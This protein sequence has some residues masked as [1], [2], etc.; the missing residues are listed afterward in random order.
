MT[1]PGSAWPQ[2]SAWH[3]T[4][5]VLGIL[6]VGIVVVVTVGRQRPRRD[7][8]F[9]LAA[10]VVTCLL[11][12]SDVQMTSMVSYRSH[13]IEHLV[14]ILVIAPL[15]A[16]GLSY[17][18]SRSASTCGLI[19]F[20]VLIPLYHLTRLGA[21]VMQ[22]GGGHFVELASFAAVGVWFWLPIYG[23]NR[24]MSDVQ[25]LAFTFVALP[26]IATTGLVLWSSNSASA[27]AV[28]MTMASMTI[29][30]L[31]NGGSVMIQWGS[32]LMMAH[33][34]ILSYVTIRDRRR[35]L[36]PIGLRYAEV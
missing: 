3:V 34:A 7:R 5:A 2:W 21:W 8:W 19:A 4:S 1:D 29:G 16:A 36:Q 20:T 22:R 26:V 11:L 27:G 25:R 18:V 30:D 6:V 14:V 31:R 10:L 17:R 32:A 33:L 13:M 15:V 35:A 9:W 28:G 12:S 24:L 23:T